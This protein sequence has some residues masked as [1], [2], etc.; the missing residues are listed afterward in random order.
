MK[1]LIMSV[2]F[3]SFLNSSCFAESIFTS[4]AKNIARQSSRC[5]GD[6]SAFTVAIAPSPCAMGYS[7]AGAECLQLFSA[8]KFYFGNKNITMWDKRVKQFGWLRSAMCISYVVY[9]LFPTQ[10]INTKTA[11]TY[12][13]VSLTF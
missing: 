7:I 10:N 5:A 12:Y 1:K 6:V 13:C 9:G 3:L 2:L 8:Y 11:A 4:F